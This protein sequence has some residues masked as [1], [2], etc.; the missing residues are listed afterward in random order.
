MRPSPSVTPG[1]VVA[2]LGPTNTGK[3]HRAVERMLAHPTGMM[4]LPL[5]LLAREVY[6]RVTARV[7]EAAVALVTGEE[8]RIP[9]RPAVLDLHRRGDAVDRTGRLP[10]R[11]RDPARRAPRARA[12]LHRSAAVCARARGDVAPGRRHHA[13]AGARADP[14]GRGRIASAAL[15]AAQCRAAA[16]LRDCRP[17]SAV[18]AFSAQRVYELAERMRARRGGAAVVL[19]ALSP[20][21]RNAQVAMYQSGEVDTL[22]ATDAIGM[23]LNLDV[24]LVAFAD[25][26]SSTGATCAALED[27]ELAQI[28]GRAGRFRHDGTFAV[29]EPLEPLPASATRAIETASLPGARA[30]VLAQR[31]AGFLVR[32]RACWRRC[33]RGRRTR[34][35]AVPRPPRTSG[36]SLHWQAAT[37]TALLLGGGGAGRATGCAWRGTS[38]RIPDFRQLRSTTTRVCSPRCS[39]SCARRGHLDRGLA[40]RACRAPR[41]GRRRHRD[42]DRAPGLHP[43]VDLRRAPPGLGRPRGGV[44]GDGPRDRGSL[45]RR[46]PRRAGA[47]VRRQH[48]TQGPPAR[49]PC[50]TARW[51]GRCAGLAGRIRWFPGAAASRGARCRPGRWRWLQ[52]RG[53]GGGTIAG[54]AGSRPAGH[55]EGTATRQRR[56]RDRRGA[57]RS[58]R[59]RGRGTHPLP[60]RRPDPRTIGARTRP[61]PTGRS[62]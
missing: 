13:A 21:A 48:R 8:K 10:G 34:P 32:R 37:E 31:R 56:Q 27:A 43:H 26:G 16:A 2:M 38:A 60:R 49:R 1:R 17:R 45:E 57:A 19:G 36:R 29:L 28:A 12:R 33:V 11:R 53:G 44:A 20:R 51:R 14:G 23:G 52:S 47:P 46:A 58:L 54:S 40:A 50:R 24:E 59:P 35:C 3:T 25:L 62:R 6:D 22:V 15:D 41:S 7:G 55:S 39:A 9:A 18:V 5:R 30:G 4:G 61:A 42:V